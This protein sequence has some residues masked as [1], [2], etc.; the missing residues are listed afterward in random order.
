MGEHVAGYMRNGGTVIAVITNDGWWGN[1]P[2]YRQHLAYGRLRCI[3]NRRSMVRSANTGISAVINQRGDVE[4]RTAWWRQTG[5]QCH[6]ERQCRANVLHPL[7]RLYRLGCLPPCGGACTLGHHPN[8]K[9][10]A[11]AA[12]NAKP[13]ANMQPDLSAIC[14]QAISIIR[15]TGAWILQES[16]QFDTGRVELKGRADLVSY[17]DKT[18]E[19]KL[20][21]GLKPLLPEAVF[22]TE[23]G[24]QQTGVGEYI[25][26]IDPLDGTT[27]FVHGLPPFAISVGLMQG[28][29][30]VLGIVHECRLNETFWA[31]AATFGAFCNE[32]PI[33]VSR[34]PEMAGVLGRNGLPLPARWALG[35]AFRRGGGLAQPNAWGAPPWALPPPIWPMWP[36]AAWMPTMNITC[37]PGTCAPVPFLCKKQAAPSQILMREAILCLAERWWPQMERCICRFFTKF[38]AILHKLLLSVPFLLFALLASNTAFADGGMYPINRLDTQAL[39]KA[40]LKIPVADIFGKPGS[41]SDAVVQLGGCTGSFVS[42][43]GVDHHQPPLHFWKPHGL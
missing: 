28:D 14:K 1:T 4:K 13:Y 42:A 36:A 43:K 18:A 41:L 8:P 3:E 30:T 35:Q 23:E 11:K 6:R 19:E 10:E 7:W 9:T 5:F 21:A 20:V 27:N 31:N 29:K 39:L 15:E 2:G 34:V 32:E 22:I 26:I 16:T 12:H 38:A 24:T 40:G 33:H 37:T 17:V 25:W